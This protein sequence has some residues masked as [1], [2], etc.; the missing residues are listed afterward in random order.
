M[1]CKEKEKVQV[2]KIITIPFFVTAIGLFLEA[3]FCD[4]LTLYFLFAAAAAAAVIALLQPC[5]AVE[6]PGGGGL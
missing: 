1:L 2:N 6:P 5:G 4:N 3:T